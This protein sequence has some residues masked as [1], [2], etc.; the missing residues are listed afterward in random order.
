VTDRTVRHLLGRKLI[1]RRSGLQAGLAALTGAL[2]DRMTTRSVS[3]ADGDELKL[4]AANTASSTT[5]LLATLPGSGVPVFRVV[6]EAGGSSSRALEVVGGALDRDDEK[7]T[8]NLQAGTALEARG[9]D[10]NA[11]GGVGLFAVGGSSD[12]RFAGP[13]MRAWQGGGE[14]SLGAEGAVLL[15]GDSDGVAGGVGLEV[16]GGSTQ[17]GPDG[18]A[19]AGLVANG[20]RGFPGL[21]YDPQPE[22]RN[23][24]LFASGEGTLG[25]VG[26]VAYGAGGVV[27]EYDS[28]VQAIVGEPTAGAVPAVAGLVGSTGFEEDD[29]V[30]GHPGVHGLHLKGGDGSTGGQGIVALATPKPGTWD[31]AALQAE[32]DLGVG[33]LLESTNATAMG[34][35]GP[36]GG[37]L[38]SGTGTAAT[39]VALS[40]TSDQQS[41]VYGVSQSGVGCDGRS[42]AGSGGVFVAQAALQPALLADNANAAGGQMG[43]KSLGMAINGSLM[44][45]DGV[46]QAVVT[47]SRGR[48]RLYCLEATT[49]LFEE[50]GTARL[51]NGRV[52]VDLDPLFLETIDARQYHVFLSPRGETDGVYVA[53]QS[54]SGFEIRARRTTASAVP[55]DWRVV[56]RR[57][58]L[59]DAH[60]LARFTPPP[61]APR[62]APRRFERPKLP[63]VPVVR[64]PK[65]PPPRPRPAPDLIEVRDKTSTAPER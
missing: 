12:T 5:E 15:G 4:A 33:A 36:K 7:P 24:G 62:P 30:P 21:D 45:Q 14:E 39:D 32:A 17:P 40:A 64:T 2:V 16:G 26:L 35:I 48:R 63:P 55:V 20:S 19:G 31:V 18:I 22:G 8:G 61:P 51:Q 10:V 57:K 47:T 28:A 9:A 52:R 49:A 54:P 6:N 43:N 41:G 60:R 59:P 3:A 13:A 46:P 44:V 38:V 58:G 50:L 56:A 37:L 23:Y 11:G 53:D 25:G 29:E 1:G 27:D 34:A 65:T 42:S